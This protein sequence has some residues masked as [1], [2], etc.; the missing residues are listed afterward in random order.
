MDRD[1][2]TQLVRV[3]FEQFGEILRAIELRIELSN[4]VGAEAVIT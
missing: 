1:V 3:N 4:P 2:T